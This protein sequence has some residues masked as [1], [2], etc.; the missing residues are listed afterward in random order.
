MA[1]SPISIVDMWFKAAEQHTYLTKRFS[2]QNR[3]PTP[4]VHSL[5]RVVYFSSDRPRAEVLETHESTGMYLVVGS[6]QLD[7]TEASRVTS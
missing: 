2:E 7:A 4:P 1:T 6:L 5:G 3:K